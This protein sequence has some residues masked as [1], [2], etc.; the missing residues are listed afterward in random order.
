MPANA[1]SIPAI[2]K[3]LFQKMV[4]YGATPEV[5][6]GLLGN[7]HQES[8][9]NPAAIQ[10]GGSKAGMTCNGSTSRTSGMA[11]GLFQ[12]DGIRKNNLL[13][14]AEKAGKPWTDVDFQLKFAFE[15]EMKQEDPFTKK[16]YG[17]KAKSFCATV[18][19]KVDCGKV[20]TNGFPDGAKGFL[21]GVYPEGATVEFAGYWERPG[22]PHLERRLMMTNKVYKEF[23]GL[24]GI[25]ATD[26]SSTTKPKE[27]S[28]KKS[29]ALGLVGERELTG[30][31]SSPEWDDV[32]TP[33]D[34]NYSGLGIGDQFRLTKAGDA[35]ASEKQPTLYAAQI[36]I[37]MIGLMFM[38]WAVLIFAC[39]M[40]DKAN[41]IFEFRAVR[42]V[43]FGQMEYVD[44]KDDEGGSRVGIGKLL[45]RLIAGFGVGLML[46]SGVFFGMV[47][48]ALTM[49]SQ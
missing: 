7:S 25:T 34:A 27:G 2:A 40:W 30:M 45:V 46:V 29:D 24:D 15:I 35:I 18:S 39:A 13:C 32:T 6:S 12:W 22:K 17:S 43:T 31:G 41:T 44:D 37:S 19:D 38:L 11:I 21:K 28:D 48:S 26:Q 3:E 1:E 9:M 8:G 42:L 36:G 49:F 20:N 16:A 4:G 23:K 10:G 33:E 5:A 47:E 14:A